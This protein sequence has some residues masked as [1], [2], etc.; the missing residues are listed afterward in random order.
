LHFIGEAAEPARPALW[1][2]FRH[3]ATHEDRLLALWV[4]AR[5]PSTRHLPQVR[6]GLFVVIDHEET[7]RGHRLHALE[8]AADLE[9]PSYRLISRLADLRNHEGFG[10]RSYETLRRIGASKRAEWSTSLWWI[11]P[12]LLA[13][14]IGLGLG[15]LVAW[16]LVLA[17]WRPLRACTFTRSW[18]I[19]MA[20]AVTPPL[21]VVFAVTL[22]VSSQPWVIGFLPKPVLV[23]VP[24]PLALA[25]TTSSLCL[26][27]STWATLQS[28]KCR[29]LPEPS[30][31]A[32]SGIG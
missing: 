29:P 11:L 20:A 9:G 28:R 6:D 25:L 27:V 31:L 24:V 8:L 18:W 16:L 1:R 13:H 3:P 14:E 7:P 23:A 5:L 15:L 19:H 2:S 10:D 17:R 21:L 30:D 12:R 4:L 26:L 32:P 22:N